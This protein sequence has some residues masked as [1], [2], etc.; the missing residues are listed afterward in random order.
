MDKQLRMG[1]KGG[2]KGNVC[3]D[4]DSIIIVKRTFRINRIF[5]IIFRFFQKIYRE[6]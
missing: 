3:S 6:S 4:T 2:Y 5:R 1:Y